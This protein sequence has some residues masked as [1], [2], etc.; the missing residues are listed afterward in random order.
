MLAKLVG[1]ITGGALSRVLDTVDKRIEAQNERE[2]VKAE[3]IKSSY[4]SRA[5]FMKAGGFILMLLFAVPLAFWFATVIF[6]SI[7]F[8]SGCAFPQTWHVAALPSPLNEWA[9]LIITAI[10]G[11][12]GVTNLT[13][14]HK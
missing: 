4:A 3:L 9:G 13:G 1:W 6:Y 11:V 2:R 8:C 5:G 12:I 10:F 7:F 14:W